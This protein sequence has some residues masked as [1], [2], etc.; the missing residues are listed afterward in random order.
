MC[1]WEMWIQLSSQFFTWGRWGSERLSSLTKVTQVISVQ[2]GFWPSLPISWVR[3][4]PSF[5]VYGAL[6][7]SWFSCDLSIRVV[8]NIEIIP[9]IYYILMNPN[10]SSRTLFYFP[11]ISTWIFSQYLELLV[12]SHPTVPLQIYN[13]ERSMTIYIFHFYIW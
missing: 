8:N 13:N 12:S 9:F 7:S 6:M 1:L 3:V 11:S 4:L 10:L 2:L 5:F